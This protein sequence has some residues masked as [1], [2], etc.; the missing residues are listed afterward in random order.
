MPI[1]Y[2]RRFTSK[3]EGSRLWVFDKGSELFFPTSPEKVAREYGFYSDEDEK[4][5]SEVVE[6]PVSP[7]LDKLCRFEHL[8]KKERG[9][10]AYY[11]A[12]FLMRVPKRRTR[13]LANAPEVIDRTVDRVVHKIHQLTDKHLLD[14]HLAMQRI[15]EAEEA[16]D[17]LNNQLPEEVIEHIRS[18]WPSKRLEQ[19]V[20][21]MKW[22]FARTDGP[23]F[24]LTTD[25]PVFFFEAYG[26]GRR[27]AELSF[28][29]SSRLALFASNSMHE[30]GL[31]VESR[32]SLVKEINRRLASSATRFICYH[33]EAPWIKAI[34][35]KKTPYLSRI[36]WD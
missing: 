23:V 15:A 5:L 29:I 28:P 33:Q 9:L 32:Q 20:F 1:S 35:L 11:L 6:S 27:E 30:D 12:V 13:A 3:K 31:F 14:N 24:F 2:L 19:A 18:P 34:A 16:R 17:K 8:D 10:L 4:K 22:R 25:N 26:L 7:I 36:S 21:N